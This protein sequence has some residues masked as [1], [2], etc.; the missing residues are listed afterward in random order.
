MSATAD[1][2]SYVILSLFVGF[3]CGGIV[4]LLYQYFKNIG[5]LERKVSELAKV[6]NH[7]DVETCTCKNCG[8]TLTLAYKRPKNIYGTPKIDSPPEKVWLHEDTW[9]ESCKLKGACR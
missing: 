7:H 6:V 3:V 9:N 4:A 1:L 8:K 2:T 5:P